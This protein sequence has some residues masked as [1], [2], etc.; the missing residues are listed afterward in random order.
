MPSESSSILSRTSLIVSRVTD[1][2]GNTRSAGQAYN[3]AQQAKNDL[4][5]KKE[6]L[7][8]EAKNQASAHGKDLNNQRDPNASLSE[9]K[10]Q[11][12][13]AA[14]N[15][16]DQ[17]SSEADRNTPNVDRD[18]AEN[19]A[20]NKAQQLKEKI[21]EK[22]REAASDAINTTKDILHDALPE[23]RREQFI[24]RLKKVVVEAQE[25]K[26]YM[27]AMTWL[28]DTLEN[29]KGH[30]QHV[31]GKGVDAAKD[32]K[33][34]P[35]ISN[36]TL[37]FRTLLERF[38]NGKSMD[39]MVKALDQ[40]Y[41]DVDNDPELKGYFSKLN[42]YVHRLL[43]EPG[44]ILDEEAEQEGRELQEG[45]K[46]FF[47]DKYKGHQEHL[48]DEIQNWF[49][50]LGDDPLNV[51]LGEDVKRLTK[52]LLFNEEGN[53]TFK[54]RLWKDVKDVILPSFIRQIGYVPIPRA[55]Y[56]DDSIDVVI[57][58]LILSGPNLFPNLISIR[59]DNSFT[60][61]PFPS[62]TKHV[63]THHHKMQLSGQG[64]QAD[65]RDVNFAFRRKTGWPKISDHGLAD[66]VV[67]GKGISFDVEIESVPNNRNKVFKVC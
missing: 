6:E 4:Q 56:S 18:Q 7:K 33:S 13:G 12:K 45:G 59:A 2:Q 15:K 57:E 49:T 65:I 28:L 30:A 35:A 29:Y 66:V 8:S 61:S 63:D 50:A 58:N 20:R 1:T 27:E 17:A 60:F 43:L 3:E 44:W 38:A 19:E 47:S 62:I 42:D 21:P 64:I 16:A 39:G 5:N 34:D 10:E 9:Q 14:Q 67:A 48:F 24:Y 26:D 36:A 51:R 23:E 46:K 55:E 41:T 11:L 22:H 52:D 40:I 32:F 37:G 31:T 54:G 53:L 25:H